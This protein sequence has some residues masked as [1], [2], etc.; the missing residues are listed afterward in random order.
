[1]SI[2]FPRKFPY[3]RNPS[4]ALFNMH[5]SIMTKPQI[6]HLFVYS[7][8]RISNRSLTY[9]PRFTNF[10]PAH[11]TRLCSNCGYEHDDASRRIYN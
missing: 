1:M 7:L 4:L 2:N 9:N 6:I 10:I 8:L 5:F 11:S 3:V